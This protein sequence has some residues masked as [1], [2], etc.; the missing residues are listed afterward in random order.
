MEYRILVVDDEYWVRDFLSISL[1]Q[2]GGFYVEVAESAAEALAKID[3]SAFH[4]VLTDMIM[5]SM[6]GVQ[7]V[8]EIAKSRP[9]ILTVLMT[10]QGT[11][12]SAVEALKHG[13]SDYLTK[14][15]NPDELV[16]RLRKVLEQR[17]RLVRVEE[18]A[19]QLEKSNE[20]LKKIDEMKSE[21]I[22]IASHELR[23]P[24]ASILTAVQLVLRGK[25]GEINEKQTK[26]LSIAEKSGWQLTNILNNLL[27][28]A[29]IESGRMELKLEEIPIQGPIELMLSALNLQAGARSIHIKMLAPETLPP[30]YADRGMVEQILTNLIGNAIKF[31]PEG[32][33]INVVAE[34]L[35]GNGNMVAIS[36]KDSGIGI[37]QDQQENVFKKFHQVENSLHRS[38]G[39]TGLGLPIAK[40]L[41]EMLQ[42]KIWLESEVG[43]GSTF[44]FTLPTQ[45]GERRDAYFRLTLDREF[46]KSETENGPLTLFLI[47]VSAPTNEMKEALLSQLEERVKKCL[48]RKADVLLKREKEKLLAAFC[49]TDRNGAQVIL[50]R[51]KENIRGFLLSSGDQPPVVNIGVAT[52]PEEVQCKRELFRLAKKRLKDEKNELENDIG[53]R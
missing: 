29:R 7:L 5:P 21:F 42:G 49:T 48:C 16:V 40:G 9:E 30:V 15:I 20:E 51:I 2:L 36:V 50:G 18:F 45:K 25:T 6:D 41:V 28:L 14:P 17:Q 12:D 31:T 13:A 24:L 8:A 4:L 23:T 44:T 43:K 39:G 32:G 1:S 11:V 34:L 37:P 35:K 52:Y 46:K 53:S 33:E 27:D 26:L 47:E 38:T 3:Q 10:G 22:S 19:A